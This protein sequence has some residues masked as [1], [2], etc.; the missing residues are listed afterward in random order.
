MWDQPCCHWPC[1]LQLCL[2]LVHICCNRSR[3]K[4]LICLSATSMSKAQGITGHNYCYPALHKP[5]AMMHMRIR[6]LDHRAKHS[7]V[8]HSEKALFTGSVTPFTHAI[9]REAPGESAAA[10]GQGL[11]L[12]RG[13]SG[14][15]PIGSGGLSGRG[16]CRK[17]AGG[18]VC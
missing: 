8:Y 18:R 13:R 4:H 12:R 17:G 2:P 1:P 5:A 14:A 10:T 6:R 15:C 11:E 7:F 16:L 3:S 9:L